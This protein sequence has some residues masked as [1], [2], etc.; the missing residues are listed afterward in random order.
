MCSPCLGIECTI[1]TECVE[2]LHHSML[3]LAVQRQGVKGGRMLEGLAVPHALHLPPSP[4]TTSVSVYLY[5]PPTVY[6]GPSCTF[7]YP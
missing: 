1:L 3:E 4:L 5:S 2:L 6:S 7:V